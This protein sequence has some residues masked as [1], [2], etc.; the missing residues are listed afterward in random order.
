M[1]L[2]LVFLTAVFVFGL[3]AP[4]FGQSI[5]EVRDAL[6]KPLHDAEFAGS[7][8]G[9]I[10]LSDE[11]ELSGANYKIDD[12]TNTKLTTVSIPFQKTFRP[13]GEDATGIYLESVVGYAQTN[14]RINDLYAGAIPGFETSV[15]TDSTTYGG[16]VGVGLGF[17]VANG[18]T[19]TPIVNVG[20]ARIENS[21]EYG[22]PGAAITAQILD[23][24]AFNWNAYTV[25][26][27]GAIRLDWIRAIGKEYEIEVVGRYD[28]R[29]TQT[30]DTTDSAQEFSTRL[31]LL[32]LRAD[33]LGPTGL[34][35]FGHALT[36]R[37][38]GG[39]RHFLEG[40]PVDVRDF[41]LLGGALELDVAGIL[42]FGRTISVNGGVI[43]GRK[44][45]GYT[46]GAALSF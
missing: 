39:Y 38:L 16:L 5:D 22:G 9:L 13:W 37:A 27:G 6:R 2:I 44:V 20:L 29:W 1:H 26:E 36:W 12:N 28:L 7:F 34:S 43:V 11:L 35:P 33:V 32:T 17:K 45:S 21:T 19:F 24:I 10:F 42:P 40:S 30:F 23:G 46:V 14:Q 3:A 18:L 31:Q 41:V 15:D 8:A 25:S 4:S